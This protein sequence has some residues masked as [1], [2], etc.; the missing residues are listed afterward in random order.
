QQTPTHQYDKVGLMTISKIKDF[1]KL[2]A[3]AEAALADCDVKTLQGGLAPDEQPQYELYHN[4]GSV[5]AQKVRCVLAELA[6]PY[7]SHDIPIVQEPWPTYQPDYVKLRVA[8]SRGQDF[9]SGHT[10][11]SSASQHGFD[12]TVVPTFIDRGAENIVIDSQRICRYIDSQI[13]QSA[14][15]PAALAAAIDEQTAIVDDIPNIAL[16]FGTHPGVDPRPQNIRKYADGGMPRKIEALKKVREIYSSD[17]TIVRAVDA[18]MVKE[19]AALDFLNDAHFMSGVLARTA[20]CIATLEGTLD[21]ETTDWLCSDS[22]TM[23]DLFWGINLYRL[24]ALGMGYLWDPEA[25][26]H[27]R[28]VYRPHVRAYAERLAERPSFRHAVADWGVA[29]N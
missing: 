20:D 12:P 8:G 1:E 4:V 5:C 23:A 26:P 3:A 29:F 21:S 19:Q 11:S 18:K 28:A 17:E 2:T 24:K 25:Y 22:Y 6:V 7:V 10:G 27:E 16:A 15:R 9:V 13:G 14:L